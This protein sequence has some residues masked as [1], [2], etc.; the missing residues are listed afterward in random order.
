MAGAKKILQAMVLL[1]FSCFILVQFYTAI[2]FSAQQE[3]QEQKSYEPPVHVPAGSVVSARPLASSDHSYKEEATVVVTHSPHTNGTIETCRCDLISINCLDS[4]RC[5]R[6]DTRTEQYAATL[7][8]MTRE[9]IKQTATFLDEED[10][11]FDN[12]PIGKATQT[13]A[14]DAWQQWFKYRIL[15][16]G[17]GPSHQSIFV[18]E[19]WYPFCQKHGLHGKSCFFRNLDAEED[20]DQFELDALEN[21]KRYIS[22]KI[23]N[24]TKNDIIQF[25]YNRLPDRFPALGYLLSF[26]HIVR[27]GFNRQ[28][29]ILN[30][31]KRHIQRVV[32]SSPSTDRVIRVSLHMRRADSC[33]H[34]KDGYEETA[35]ELDSNAQQSGY[36][37]CYATGVYMDAL[38]RV[39]ALAEGKPRLDIYLSTDDSGTVMDEIRTGYPEAY[40]EWNWNILNYSR[41]IFNY[42]GYIEGTE[43]HDKAIL[44]ESAVA[45][46]WHL[47]H[48]QVFV[49][50]LG[51]RFGKISWLLSMARR[52]AFVPFFTV[53]GHSFCCEI[54]EP[55][56]KM[57]PYIKNMEQCMLFTHQNIDMSDEELEAYWLHGS[58]IRKRAVLERISL[59]EEYQGD[60]R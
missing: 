45:D 47:S 52:N 11:Q 20:F 10:G 38:Y 4:I 16:K 29:P 12:D 37:L 41:D 17:F 50:H 3:Q 34:R 57:K 21:N 32:A 55:C 39:Q 22:E 33:D 8:I 9:W 30:T 13:Q 58:E 60:H 44:G 51:S 6:Q 46:L 5:L 49:G 19:T 28:T 26:A 53:D 40:K 2:T 31:Y 54:D 14:R 7:G 23:E 36:R 1:L 56:G 48:G 59:W 27:I 24:D 42:E 18:N 43:N 35:S 25:R 15:P